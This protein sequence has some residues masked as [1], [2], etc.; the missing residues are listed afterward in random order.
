M[1]PLVVLLAIAVLGIGFI[2]FTAWLRAHYALREKELAVRAKEAE[3]KLLEA[4]A[5][6]ALPEFLDTKDA[7]AVEAWRKARQEV[8]A[9][10]L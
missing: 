3:A 5:R 9:R 8:G 4:Q 10:E 2:G 1:D 7:A 6:A